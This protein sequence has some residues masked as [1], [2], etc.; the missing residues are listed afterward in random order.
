[1]RKKIIIIV[2]IV[3]L[4]GVEGCSTK[5]V[6]SS[7]KGLT[8]T[9]VTPEISSKDKVVNTYMKKNGLT[10]TAKDVQF[11]MSNNLDKDFSI[12]G[13]ATLDDYYNYGFKDDKNYFCIKVKQ[14]DI[15]KNSWYLYCDRVSFSKLFDDLKT[16]NKA[17][18]A[19]CKISKGV[20]KSSQGNMAEVSNVEWIPVKN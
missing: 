9:R 7:N 3:V 16:G 19:T 5:P 17:I 11:D 1:M 15:S 18:V 20:Y 6:E 12:G 10:L 8:E 14:D 4:L 13:I 2:S